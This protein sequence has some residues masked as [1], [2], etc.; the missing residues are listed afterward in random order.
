MFSAMFHKTTSCEYQYEERWE[1]GSVVLRNDET[2]YI[3]WINLK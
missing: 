3:F 2:Y 1:Q